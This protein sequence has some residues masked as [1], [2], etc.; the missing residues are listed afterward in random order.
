MTP[1]H[2]PSSLAAQRGEPSYVWRFGQERRLKLI[3][4]WARLDGATILEAGCGLG[5]YSG[6][7]RRHY[8]PHVEAFDLE[9]E[10]VAVAQ[11]GTPHALVATAEALPYRANLFDTILSN[12]VIE[13][14]SDDRL[15]VAEMVRTLKPGGRLVLFCPNR[16]YPV[17]QHGHYWRGQYHFGNTPLVNYLPDRWR[18][19][20]V[21]HV[22]T[23]SASGL[24]R[25]FEGQPVH[26]IHHTRIFGGYD[27]IVHR[28]PR[29]GRLLRH[30]LYALERTPLRFFALS[31]LL[32][33]EKVM[34]THTAQ[35][36]RRPEP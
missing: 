16:W 2:H 21:P 4:R 26:I 1:A 33:V 10:R 28:F 11:Q 14:V 24:K 30:I 29:A 25:L 6:Q 7:F 9:P 31:H 13:H 22:R 18:N 34:P 17:E 3:A 15:A 8:S 32:I 19:R 27:N 5:A 23:Y 35:I 12:E 36:S 20:L